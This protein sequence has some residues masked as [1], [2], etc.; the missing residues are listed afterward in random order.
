MIYSTT[1][2]TAS[3]RLRDSR[4]I[5]DLL[6]Q[7]A[8]PTEWDRQLYRENALQLTSL[9]ATRRIVTL[10]R[11]RLET[12]DAAL[13]LMVRDGDRDLSL[14]ALLAAAI[15]HSRVL[16]DF[17]DI[18][19]REQRCLF[20][21]KLTYAVWRDYVE[22]C[23]GRDPEMSNWSDSTF[24]RLRSTVFTILAEAGCI[25]DTRS[26]LLRNVFVRDE[27]AAYLK[28]RNERYVLRCLEVTT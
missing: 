16:G 22:G 2:T 3:L 12:M 9:K 6:I 19:V 5:A 13:W 23:R 17:L 1:I 7:Q 4:L 20:A 21:T 10:L 28:E 14:Q 25:A 8:S 24:V 11:A 18:A 26:L 27:L 15:K